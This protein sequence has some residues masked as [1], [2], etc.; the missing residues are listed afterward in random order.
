MSSVQWAKRLSVEA[1]VLPAPQARRK[2]LFW[3]NGFTQLIAMSLTEECACSTNFME[4]LRYQK[5]HQKGRSGTCIHYSPTRDKTMIPLILGDEFEKSKKIVE[6]L[7]RK[8][9]NKGSSI[10]A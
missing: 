6:M 5:Y 3:G 1:S 8:T 2:C 4:L 7:E 9:C 10:E